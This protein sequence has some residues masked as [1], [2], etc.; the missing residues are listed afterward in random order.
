MNN[1]NAGVSGSVGATRRLSDELTVRLGGFFAKI[2][3]E[4]DA[5][6]G[7]E[8]A[9][10]A[11]GGYTRGAG[12]GG[13]AGESAFA[14]VRAG[15]GGKLEGGYEGVSFAAGAYKL[16]G[17]LGAGFK[18]NIEARYQNGYLL[19]SGGLALSAEV[20]VGADVELRINPTAVGAA[21]LKK[22]VGLKSIE[23]LGV[24]ET[25]RKAAGAARDTV[26]GAARRAGAALGR[27]FRGA[28]RRAERA[29]PGGHGLRSAGPLERSG[30][31]DARARPRRPRRASRSA[32]RGCS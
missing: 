12:A 9:V 6:A 22:A 4:A 24:A 10:S 16:R 17:S 26:G 18:A 32:A 11:E 15:V 14:G 2:K 20:G 8:A 1:V 19:L 27:L 5:F 3:A 25:A 21:V 13:A 31:R 30:L 28:P 29:C 7:I 23:N